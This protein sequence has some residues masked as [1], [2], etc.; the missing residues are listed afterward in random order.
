MIDAVTGIFEGQEICQTTFTVSKQGVD[1][2]G[3]ED[4][5]SSQNINDPGIGNRL[6]LIEE[7]LLENTQHV[8]LINGLKQSRDL[9]GKDF[10][11]EMETGT[12]KTY[13]YLRSM[14]ELH[15]AC[16][17]PIKLTL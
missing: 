13:V 7:E 4:I 1:S 2:S 3:H 10:T 17:W 11:V 14:L 9:V 5:F 8:Q 15:Q 12:G 16:Q 6:R